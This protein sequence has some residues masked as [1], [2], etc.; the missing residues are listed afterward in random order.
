MKTFR[1]PP[2][3]AAT[4]AS[5]SQAALTYAACGFSVVPLSGKRP[6]IPWHSWQ[7]RAAPEP[8]IRQWCAAGLLSNVG[9]VC[10]PASAN[11]VVLDLDDPSGYTAFASTFSALANT[12]TVATGGGLGKH[13]Y[14]ATAHL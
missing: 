6:T 9:L 2:L 3:R 7:S 14:F 13:L 4:A 8:L 5:V 10:G 1:P 11:L 12:Y